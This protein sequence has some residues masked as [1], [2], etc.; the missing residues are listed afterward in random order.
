MQCP[1][2]A[3]Y[4][5]FTVHSM[6]D[7]VEALVLI[8]YI[9]RELGVLYM[10]WLPFPQHRSLQQKGVT[11][12]TLGVVLLEP[13]VSRWSLAQANTPTS[14]MST[15]CL[16]RLVTVASAMRPVACHV[17]AHFGQRSLDCF[18]I[19]IS[20]QALPAASSLRVWDTCTGDASSRLL[21]PSRLAMR[22]HA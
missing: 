10:K 4:T 16:W 20:K 6:P 21:P 1:N 8:A 15:S 19:M 12:H 13:Y 3:T 22:H 11:H 18:D 9:R 5:L 7:P 2:T 17:P 14:D